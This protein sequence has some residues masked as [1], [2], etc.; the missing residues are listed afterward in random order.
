VIEAASRAVGRPIPY[1]IMERRPGD[2]A[3]VWADASRAERELGWRAELD[4]D[5]M[6]RDAW[7]WQERNPQGYASG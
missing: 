6:C 1:E 3:A 2:A 4:L 7:N 5:A